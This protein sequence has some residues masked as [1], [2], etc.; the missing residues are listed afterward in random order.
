[1]HSAVGGISDLQRITAPRSRCSAIHCSSAVFGVMPRLFRRIIA[2]AVL[3]M[4][5]NVERPDQPRVSG[6][7]GETA[8]AISGASR[9]KQ[10]WH[11]SPSA[12]ANTTFLM[13]LT[14]PKP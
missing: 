7:T 3:Q 11:T 12:I 9:E 6:F 4:G 13:S 2:G 10:P 14:R 5:R 1:M 8:A